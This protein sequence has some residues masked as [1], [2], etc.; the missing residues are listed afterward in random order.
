MTPFCVQFGNH[1]G[2]KIDHFGVSRGICA[3]SPG[4]T[5]PRDVFCFFSDTSKIAKPFEKQKHCFLMVLL[6]QQKSCLRFKSLQHDIN[7]FPNLVQTWSK[8]DIGKGVES[9]LAFCMPFGPTMSPKTSPKWFQILYQ[10]WCAKRAL[11][12]WSQESP[13][14][15]LAPID[16]GLGRLVSVCHR[17][18]RDWVG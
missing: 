12:R 16:P 9:P 8:N 18:T 17:S 14:L 7:M 10:K 6:Y 4:A 5:S 15:G 3:E 11:K 13:F 1:L 2:I